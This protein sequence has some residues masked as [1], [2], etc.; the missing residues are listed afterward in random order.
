MVEIQRVQSF[1]MDSNFGQ[2]TGI[3]HYFNLFP[4]KWVVAI[5]QQGRAMTKTQLPC[6][7]FTYQDLVHELPMRTRLD[8]HKLL[9]I[10]VVKV[11][12]LHCNKYQAV[13]LPQYLY[14]Y[15]Y[16]YMT[17]YFYTQRCFWEKY[18]P[19]TQLYVSVPRCFILFYIQLST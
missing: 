4:V 13:P 18:H 5:Q 19:S 8:L 15:L 16:F 11:C 3:S 9:P 6:A 10:C 17:N 7:C 1:W 2:Q 12:Q 14:Q